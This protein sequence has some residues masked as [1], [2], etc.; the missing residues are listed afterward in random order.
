[1]GL[2][3]R[4]PAVAFGRRALLRACLAISGA[5]ATACTSERV[6]ATATLSGPPAPPPQLGFNL[7]S[8]STTTNSDPGVWLRALADIK[9]LGVRRV[10]VVCY[11]FLHQATGLITTNSEYGLVPGPTDEVV[12]A[13]LKEGHRKG[14]DV[15]LNPFLEVDNP[16][17]I[18]HIWRGSVSFAQ[19]QLDFFF[20]QYQAYLRD[21]AAIIT[22]A[23]G[24]RLYVGSELSRLSRDPSAQNSWIRVI[25]DLYHRLP[26]DCSLSYAANYDEF[27]AVPF[28][29]A[30]T[31]ISVDAYFKLASD[32]QAQGLNR[33]TLQVLLKSW[34]SNLLLLKNFSSEQG[35]PCSISEWGTVPFD[36]TTSRPW[37]WK[38]SQLADPGEQH[39]AYRSILESIR[40]QGSWLHGCDFW[41]WRM[42]GNEGSDYGIDL[43]SPISEYIR[44]YTKNR[45][46]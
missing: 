9:S 32:R 21:A 19:P 11:R 2:S 6:D 3:S 13:V 12:S 30:L 28:W 16:V 33:P 42:P 18:G 35:K 40:P 39:T 22:E 43:S 5:S 27:S 23:G 45:T 15:G 41:H 8:W 10:T 24:T 44:E 36:M 1:M 25:K 14:L 17:S 26:S 34:N 46:S 37:N 31:N 4:V 7:V 38:P 20:S 29:S